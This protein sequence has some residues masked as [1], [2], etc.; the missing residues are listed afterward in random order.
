MTINGTIAVQEQQRRIEQWAHQD[1][2]ITV[3]II[4]LVGSTGLNLTAADVVI[5]FVSIY[6][7]VQGWILIF[8]SGYLLV[9]SIG[10][11]DYRSG[12]SARPDEGRQSIPNDCFAHV[13]RFD[14]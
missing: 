9:T 7:Y 10:Q 4:S 14:V 13:R 1:S 11:S 5:H 8:L 12:T 2:G 6:F 3:L